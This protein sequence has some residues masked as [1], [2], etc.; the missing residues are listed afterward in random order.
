MPAPVFTVGEILSSD[1]M[2]KVGLWKVKTF[3]STAGS[4]SLV[5]T[6]AFTTDYDSY[7]ILIKGGS[8]SATA[9]MLMQL[10]GITTGYY[11]ASVFGTFAG[12]APAT[13]AS[14]NAST[15][16]SFGQG[17]TTTTSGMLDL[18]LVSGE[19][20]WYTSQW[21]GPATTGT[22]YSGGG[23]NASTTAVTSFTLTLSAGTFNAGVTVTVY[24]YNL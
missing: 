21:V 4:A 3:N 12:A 11:S 1:D 20:R 10:G 9:N 2:N 13:V 24:G 19:P 16:S 22:V 14:A 5:C 6:D 23:Y 8:T 15:W 17:T 18:H 7:R